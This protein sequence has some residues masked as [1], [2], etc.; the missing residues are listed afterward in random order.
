MALNLQSKKTIVSKIHEISKL[1][2]S[3]IIADSNGIETNKITELRKKARKLRVTIKIV[4]NN[5]LRLAIQGTH[6]ECLK[7]S[8]KGPSLI[9]Y[10]FIH[11]GSAARLFTKFS[12]DNV[13][14]K[15]ISAV[16][17]QKL[18]TKT[19]INQLANMPTY[20]ESII[21]LLFIM[22]EASVGK[23]VRILFHLSKKIN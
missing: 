6:L 22:K 3:A 9:G 18:L 5:L 2:L 8:L 14:F 15:I 7:N 23:I 10:S 17:E 1:A 11:P 4:Q 13:K 16:F 21:K 19:Q 12:K 20:E